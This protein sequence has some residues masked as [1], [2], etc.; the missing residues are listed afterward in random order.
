MLMQRKECDRQFCNVPDNV[1]TTMDW[2]QMEI[3][4]ESI[5]PMSSGQTKTSAPPLAC[6][7]ACHSPANCT[8]QAQESGV[9]TQDEQICIL[10]IISGDLPGWHSSDMALSRRL[11]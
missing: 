11:E 5:F 3:Y 6:I 1:E 10:E 2:G 4:I 8:C 7:I 9:K